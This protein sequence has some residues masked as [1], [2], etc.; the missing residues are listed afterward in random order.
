MIKSGKKLPEMITG[1]L[2]F[3]PLTHTDKQF[4]HMD[5]FIKY[6]PQQVFC[7]MGSYHKHQLNYV[8]RVI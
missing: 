6:K 2:N 5:S 4:I 8:T 1:E 7:L 3:E